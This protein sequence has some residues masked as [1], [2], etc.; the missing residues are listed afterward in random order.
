VLVVL[1]PTSSLPLSTFT[2]WHKKS[3]Q[4]GGFHF[5]R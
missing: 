3:L 4:I 2:F 5:Y 1:S